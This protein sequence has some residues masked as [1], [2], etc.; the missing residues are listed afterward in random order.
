MPT[1][2]FN[3][4][5]WRLLFPC[6]L[7]YCMFCVCSR[8]KER[9]ESGCLDAAIE[10]MLPFPPLSLSTT[11][12]F[13]INS[14]FP[15]SPQVLWITT[16]GYRPPKQC[17]FLFIFSVFLTFTHMLPVMSP[18]FSSLQEENGSGANWNF[19]HLKKQIVVF[20]GRIYM[21]LS[22]QKISV[23]NISRFLFISWISNST[24]LFC[25]L[26]VSHIDLGQHGKTKKAR[27]TLQAHRIDMSGVI[28]F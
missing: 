15:S 16:K 7:A 23:H 6:E 24:D 22:L 11:T 13:L 25:S 27:H 18:C 20:K 26:H 4:H 2:L 14:S 10:V 12:S 17:L 8:T 9:C 1:A 3:H 19:P 5:I 28:L 21:K